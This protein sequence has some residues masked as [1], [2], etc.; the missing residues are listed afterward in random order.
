MLIGNRK[1][2]RLGELIGKGVMSTLPFLLKGSLKKYRGINA[3]D[4]AHAMVEASKLDV[5][6]MVAHHY[7]DMM[8]TIKM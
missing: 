2:L 1:E 3:S 6:G 4:V 5:K 7:E 8:K